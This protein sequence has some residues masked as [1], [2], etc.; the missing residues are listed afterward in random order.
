MYLLSSSVP[1][2]TL[3][4][5]AAA[6]FKSFMH[7]LDVVLVLS[8]VESTS[9]SVPCLEPCGISLMLFCRS[10]RSGPLYLWKRWLVVG[11]SDLSSV[12]MHLHV[13]LYRDVV[14]ATQI[15][16]V[17]A[18]ADQSKSCFVGQNG[19]NSCSAFAFHSLLR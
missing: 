2:A 10:F 15:P 7:L 13:D 5:S 3:M 9:Y 14:A 11:D 1:V 4:V 19:V 17:S 16:T 8:L 18:L 12:S 6:M